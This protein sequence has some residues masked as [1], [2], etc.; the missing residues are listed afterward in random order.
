MKLTV[1]KV[2]S[3]LKQIQNAKTNVLECDV[4]SF[5][6][7]TNQSTELLRSILVLCGISMIN[8]PDILYVRAK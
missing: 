4:F 3:M 5:L 1:M 8:L 2:G 7:I 6:C